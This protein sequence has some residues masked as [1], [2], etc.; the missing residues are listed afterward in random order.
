MLEWHN[1][2]KIHRIGWFSKKDQNLV[3]EFLQSKKKFYWFPF[4][5]AKLKN[6]I[7][8]TEIEIVERNCQ[9]T[10]EWYFWLR[11]NLNHLL[12]SNRIGS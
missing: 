8:Q 9:K 11:E 12:K 3:Y 4:K 6:E 2:L 10:K 7:D 1:L 5:R